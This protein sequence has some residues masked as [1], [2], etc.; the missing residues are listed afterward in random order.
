[1]VAV[2]FVVFG[3]GLE[4]VTVTTWATLPLPLPLVR[5]V[6]VACAPVASQQATGRLPQP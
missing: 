3:S 4:L 2:L 1:M 6:T 5:I